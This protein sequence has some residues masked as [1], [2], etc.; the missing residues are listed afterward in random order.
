[1]V[2]GGKLIELADLLV[3]AERRRE[4]IGPLTGEA[5]DLTVEDAYRIQL[6]VLEVKIQEKRRVV[7]KKIGL[8]SAAMQNLLGVFE[9]DYGHL[10]T[11][12]EVA[13]GGVIPLDELMQPKVEPEI[14]FLL[15]KDLTGPGVSLSD[16]L[17]VTEAV[18]PALEIVD[19]RIRDWRI[20]I[21][22][23]VADNAS[24]ARFVLGGRLTRVGDLD[25][26]LTGLVFKKNGEI[27]GTA[28]GAAV[29]GHPAAAVAWLANKLAE[30][31]IGLKAG[32]VILSG[33]FLAAVPPVA[34]DFFEACFDRLGSAGVRFAG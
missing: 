21:Q 29:A 11:G 22:D 1:L 7:G 30:F 28:A 16:V 32:E 4:A 23:T 34:G 6:K 10:L 12:M 9:P 24:S 17:R 8:T 13:D 3:R 15:K 18:V 14:A 2:D 5:P 25:L 19:S 26:S 31:G 27:M 20:K 33:A